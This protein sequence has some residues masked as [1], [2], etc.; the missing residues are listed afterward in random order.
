[1][2]DSKKIDLLTVIVLV[3]FSISGL[4]ALH[5]D[6]YLYWFPEWFM[7]SLLKGISYDIPRYSFS[8]FQIPSYFLSLLGADEYIRTKSIGLSLSMFPIVCLF[9]TW[10]FLNKTAH[11]GLLYPILLSFLFF[12]FLTSAPAFN[13][14][15]H[16][17]AMFWV[18]ASLLIGKYSGKLRITFSF[19]YILFFFFYPPAS[20]TG[21]LLLLWHYYKYKNG[22]DYNFYLLTTGTILSFLYI[23]FF[24]FFSEYPI[25]NETILGIKAILFSP[26]SLTFYLLF[27]FQ[28]R[29]RLAESKRF[30]FQALLLLFLCFYIYENWNFKILSSQYHYRPFLYTIG[31]TPILFLN[32]FSIEDFISRKLLNSFA[33]IIVLIFLGDIRA[34][35][36]FQKDIALLE[37]LSKI[38]DT[39]KKCIKIEK[40]SSLISNYEDINS[41]SYLI[42]RVSVHNTILMPTN[43]YTNELY[44]EK[45]EN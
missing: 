36:L 33:V 44:K 5:V 23:V 40:P 35:Y 13:G 17:F 34:S 4:Y 9:F 26:L 1:V 2:S 45:C 12:Y 37:T 25:Y 7:Q 20:F 10:K 31:F 28:F 42:E 30:P 38:N 16:S 15:L 41:L 11:K 29:F 32:N 19:L 14:A 22:R 6:R 39:N 18:I 24:K 21:S 43:S 3:F 27:Y 8:L